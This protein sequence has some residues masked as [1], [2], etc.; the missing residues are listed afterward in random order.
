MAPSGNSALRP[1]QALA[2]GLALLLACAAAAARGEERSLEIAPGKTIRYSLVGGGD[3]SA[4]PTAEKLLRHLAEGDIEAASRLSNAPHRRYEELARYRDAVGESEFKR[5]YSQ[6]FAPANRVVAEVAIG[7][8]RLLIWDLGEA[9]HRLDGQYY[10]QAE[11][12]FL[13]DE[14]P[15]EMRSRLRRVLEA[16]RSGALKF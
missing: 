9:G 11:G 4:K 7:A 8:H 14:V 16:Y 1:R 2:W 6:F 13:M 12:R 5:V 10:V 15:G 3:A